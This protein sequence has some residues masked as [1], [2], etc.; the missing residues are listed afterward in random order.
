MR[1]TG[2]NSVEA[3]GRGVL[4]LAPQRVEQFVT[5]RRFTFAAFG[6]KIFA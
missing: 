2:L 3:P 1:L 5:R 4:Y 6:R